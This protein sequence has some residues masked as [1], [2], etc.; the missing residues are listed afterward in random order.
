MG[1]DLGAQLKHAVLDL[2]H[3]VD[4]QVLE[5]HGPLVAATGVNLL[6]KVSK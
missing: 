1:L 3:K 6:K 5:D 4:L 2:G